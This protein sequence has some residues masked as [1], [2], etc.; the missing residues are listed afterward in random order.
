MR[1][2]RPVDVAGFCCCSACNRYEGSDSAVGWGQPLASAKRFETLVITWHWA[3]EDI[4]VISANLAI[5]LDS[6]RHQSPAKRV[7]PLLRETAVII[8]V[9]V[10]GWMEEKFSYIN[11]TLRGSG[12][13]LEYPPG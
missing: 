8:V 7:S 13:W 10:M 12:R 11:F 9:R 5:S 1:K 4:A 2:L 6:V 3:K